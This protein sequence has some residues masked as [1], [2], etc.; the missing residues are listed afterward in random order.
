[1][2]ET[3]QERETVP[4]PESGINLEVIMKRT[5]IK[6]GEFIPLYIMA[7]P[8]LIYLFCNNYMPMFG[9][10]LAFKKLDVRKG[11]LGSDWAGLNNFKFLFQ[12]STAFTIIRNTVLYNVVFIVLGMVISVTFAILLNEIRSRLVSSVYQSLVL[13]PFLMSWVVVSYL[14]YALLANDTGLINNSILKAL[15]METVNWYMEKKY[16]PFILFFCNIWKSTGYS[17]IIYYSSIVGISKE[18][19][20]AAAVDGATKWQQIRKI[21]LPLLKPTLITMTILSVGRIF[22]SDFGLFYQIPRNS[23]ALYGVTQTIDVYVYNALM[24]NGDF[25][26]SSAASVF[27]A[28]VGFVLVVT[29]NAIARRYSKDNA[30]F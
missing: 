10:L 6:W 24:K 26:M 23:G 22:A 2:E 12:S 7:L 27:Q 29:T 20:E 30:I 28:A 21:T 25:G 8:G 4:V 5:K 19:Y 15:G 18:Y 14:S 11:I 3:E 9:V 17:M 13:I 1:M 16:W